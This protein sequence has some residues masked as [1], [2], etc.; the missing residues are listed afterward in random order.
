[1]EPLV[2]P[3]SPFRP[4]PERPW[5]GVTHGDDPYDNARRALAQVDL[6]PAR[7]KR[8]LLKPNAGRIAAAGSG[9][10]TEPQ[11]VAAAIDAF[12]DAGAEVAVGDSPIV[13][14]K[15]FEALDASGISAVARERDCPVLDLDARRKVEVA[16]PDGR[17]IQSLK[18]CPDVLEHDLVV[19]IPVM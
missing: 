4:R 5:V 2:L 18:L 12:R 9:I 7:G 16:L 10:I 6:S 15:R 11:V 13:G 14:V 1:M 19:S 8:V 17:A 3:E